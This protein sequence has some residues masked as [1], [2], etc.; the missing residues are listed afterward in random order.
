MTLTT[1]HALWRSDGSSAVTSGA[2]ALPCALSSAVTTSHATRTTEERRSSSWEARGRLT[3]SW[4]HSR[5]SSSAAR[6]NSGSS[7]CSAAV[8][9]SHCSCASVAALLSLVAASREISG[10]QVV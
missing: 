1:L 2:I 8:R 10:A 6:W 3:A 7:S 4:T 5:T 9:V